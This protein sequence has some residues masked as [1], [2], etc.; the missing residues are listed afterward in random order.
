MARFTESAR[1][2]IDDTVDLWRERCLLADG[3]LI[4][5]D[6]AGVWTA[7][8]L[9]DLRRRFTDQ[10][11]IGDQAG[12]SFDSKWDVQLA[13]AALDV[14]L[15]GAEV[16]LVYFLFAR[17]VGQ[18]R[19][20]ETVT[21]SLEGVELPADSVAI[22]AL[23]QWIGS[24]G[25][26]FN[27]RRDVQI[28]FLLDFVERFKALGVDAGRE[29]LGSPW[30]LR[31]FADAGEHRREM[32]HI[33]LH[34]LCPDEFERMSS[35]THK[36]EIAEALADVLDDEAPADLDER[37]LAIRGR[38]SEWLPKGNTPGGQLDF[39][40]P[41]L[42]GIWSTSGAGGEGAGDLE[43]LRWKKQLILYGPP[44]TGKTWVADE[45]AAQVIRRAALERWGPRAFFEREDAVEA[46]VESNVLRLQ[47][48]PAFGYEQ[49][50]RGLRLEG[51]TTRYRPGALPNF[52]EALA[53][54]QQP[55]GLPALPGVLL[56]DEINRTDLSAMFGEAF[57]LLE[58]DQRGK[59]RELPGFDHDEPASVLV[60]PK[61]LFVIGTMNEIDQSV[62]TLDF[63]LRRR[64][65]WRLCGFDRTALLA[66]ITDRWAA[67][68]PRWGADRAAAQ[69]DVFA[70]RAQQLND[71]I[72]ASPELG[73][74]YEIGHT[75][76]ADI[77]FFLG[78]WAQSRTTAPPNGTWLWTR[79]GSPQPALGDLWERSLRPLLEQYLSGSDVRDSELQTLHKVFTAGP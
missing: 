77:T 60:I 65:L 33:L 15:L 29:L 32:R 17:S 4:F 5:D 24:A 3:S 10:K 42:R 40:H 68:V 25:I 13:D 28:D 58:R 37:I 30:E 48:H 70:D 20:L 43:S 16:L 49:F 27:T 11:L 22:A 71:H 57:S 8:N 75:Y 69:L 41:P 34:L 21:R 23:G 1:N 59:P 76:F 18:A 14:R 9:A 63:A 46:A 67:D 47:L 56:L 74:Q 78:R 35:G 7:A 39:Y 6:R 38:L 26:G 19:K 53:G 45:L 52:V 12:G 31:D 61:D 55:E 54:Q 51:D 50:I 73:R 36:R 72:A 44:G 62:E 79:N 66:I 64:F 2:L